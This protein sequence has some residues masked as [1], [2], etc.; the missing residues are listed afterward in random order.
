MKYL[1]L[2]LLSFNTLAYDC[3]SD[4]EDILTSVGLPYDKYHEV[5]ID[6]LCDKQ[7]EPDLKVLIENKYVTKKAVANVKKV[8]KPL[9]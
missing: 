8:I 5:I 1:I 2:L 7:Y 6:A 9:K 3:N 4:K